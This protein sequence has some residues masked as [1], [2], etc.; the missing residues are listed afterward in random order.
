RRASEAPGKRPRQP[1]VTPKRTK[2]QPSR[3]ASRAD[4]VRSCTTFRFALRGAEEA[5][6][7]FGKTEVFEFSEASRK[8]FSRQF[9]WVEMAQPRLPDRSSA[10]ADSG[11][12]SPALRRIVLK[13]LGIVEHDLGLRHAN[14]EAKRSPYCV[15]R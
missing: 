1:H 13:R 6:R 14:D 11:H 12:I 15:A 3:D 10:R 7:N 8:Q 4:Y 5:N 9:S 2:T